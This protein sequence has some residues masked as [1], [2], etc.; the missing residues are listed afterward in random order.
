MTRLAKIL[1]FVNVAVALL[2]A[3]WGVALYTNRVDWKNEAKEHEDPI[4]ARQKARAEAE[5]KWVAA[6]QQVVFAEN[7]R[8]QYQK[9][10]AE[11]INNLLAGNQPVRTIA[12]RNGQMMFDQQG[13]PFMEPLGT[14]KQKELQGL[15]SIDTL[16]KNYTQLQAQINE[17]LQEVKNLVANEAQLTAQIIGQNMQKGL[18]T[19][20]AEVQDA[21]RRAHDEQEFLKPLLYNRQVE[22]QLLTERKERLQKRLKEVQ[23][24][25]VARE[26]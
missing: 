23:S 8:P 20:L 3:Y 18:R 5:P 12:F 21:E 26:P 9:F 7:L 6:G 16:Q 1:V 4:R 13:R 14:R 10:Y 11:Q 2:F 24:S 15:A 17:V 22:A 25:S 19:I